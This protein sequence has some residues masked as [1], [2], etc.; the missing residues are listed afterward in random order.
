MI[1]QKNEVMEISGIM[2]ETYCTV[3]LKTKEVGIGD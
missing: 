3:L 2:S 1:R